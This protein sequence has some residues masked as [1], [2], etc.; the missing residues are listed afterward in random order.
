MTVSCL[1]PLCSVV[2]PFSVSLPDAASVVSDDST[3]LS[4]P[5]DPLAVADARSPAGQPL[6]LVLSASSSG[7][8]GFAQA[9][10]GVSYAPPQGT[11]ARTQ[12][13]RPPSLLAA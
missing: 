5:T 4:V 6:E 7:L 10:A 2:R 12:V 8:L 13:T 9:V 1:C 3:L 11:D